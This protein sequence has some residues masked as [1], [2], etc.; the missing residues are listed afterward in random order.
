MTHNKIKVFFFSK[1]INLSEAIESIFFD[2]VDFSFQQLERL[3]DICFFKQYDSESIV[4]L[5]LSESAEHFASKIDKKGSNFLSEP[6]IFLLD[7]DQKINFVNSKTCNFF[8]IMR[9][10]IR[11]DELF[12][13]IR[14]LATNFRQV[15]ESLIIMQSNYFYPKKNLMRNIK[16]QSIRLTEKEAEIINVL[17]REK[18]KI[19]SKDV[20][21]KIIWGYE[22]PI[23]THTL[24]THIYR[25]RKKI[26]AGLGETK[27]ILKNNKGY[28]LNTL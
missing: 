20:L 28:Y 17:Y 22:K 10:P 23:S 15:N 4:I 21:L 19:L 12:S 9:K 24:E 2:E 16:G 3:D 27:L 1:K 11:V 25:L 13:K 14:I 5:D 18:D 6:I 8:Q 26:M 7:S